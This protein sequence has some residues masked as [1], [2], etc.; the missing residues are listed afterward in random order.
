MKRLF[1]VILLIAASFQ[2]KAACDY[3]TSDDVVITPNG[4]H[5][6][7][8]GYTQIYVL[9][10]SNGEIV[11]TSTN[12]SFGPQNFGS[13]QAYGINY[14]DANAPTTLPIVGSNINDI[15]D[16][17]VSLSNSLDITVCETSSLST[18]E[19]SGD[20]II[21]ALNPDY[22]SDPSYNQII[23][24][25]DDAT[26]NIV[27][28]SNFD[29]NN[30]TI[31][32]TTDA[33]IGDLTNGNYTAYSIN[34]ENSETLAGLGIVIGNSWTGS[35]G[36][37]CA[38]ASPGVAILVDLCT[39]VCG[40]CSTPDCLIAGPYSDYSTAANG[41]NHCSQIN[42]ISTTPVNG[43]TFTSY[44]QLTS[45]AT[46]TVGVV[47]SVGV[48]AVVGGTPCPVTRTATLY[49][50][51]GMCN[52]STAIS[53]STTTANGSPFYNPEFTG[54]TPNTDY[55]LEVI[56][57]VPAGC[58]MVDH[59][60][61]YYT[62][63][64]C[65]ASTGT[66]TVTGGT[67]IATNDYELENCETITFTATNED[68]NGGVLTYGWAIFNCEP[69]LPLSAADI[70]D[71][72]NNPCYVGS[73]YGLT[74]ND[75]D[76]AG[77]SA[78]MNTLLGSDET[79]LWFLPY[80]SDVD[81]AVDNDGD[82][83]YAIG[84]L[85]HITYIPPTCGDCNSPTCAADG[86][87]T[88]DDRTYNLCNDPCADLNNTTIT[89]FHTVTTDSF[90]NVGVVQS[91][92]ATC[93]VSRTAVLRDNSNS[94]GNP[95]IMPT[96]SNANGVGSGFNPEW[97]G[98]TPN[99]DYTLIITTVIGAGCNYDYACVDFYGVPGCQ[100]DAGNT[101][102]TTSNTT[103]NDYILCWNESITFTNST[104]VLSGFNVNEGF[105]YAVY[106]NPMPGLVPN[107]SDPSFIEILVGSG[108]NATLTLANDG[109][110]TPPF[111]NN[112]DHTIYL[113]PV[114]LDD[115]TIPAIDQDNDNCFDVGN[116]IQVTFLNDI[117]ITS[118]EDCLN[119][120][121]V[122]EID[123]GY[124]EYFNG[125]YSITCLGDGVL[126]NSTVLT[127]GGLTSIASLLPGDEHNIS[128]VDD[129]GC[130]QSTLPQ[131]YPVDL[132]FDSIVF[133]DPTCDYLCNGDVTIYSANASQFAFDNSAYQ[134]SNA[135]VDICA[136]T[137]TVTIEDNN[138]YVDSLITLVN[139]AT[140][141]LAISDDTTI[142][143]NGT[144]SLLAMASGGTGTLDYY[145]DQILSNS[146]N[147][148]AP[149]SNT[150]YSAYA[151]DDNSCSTDT[152]SVNVTILDALT[153]TTSPSSSICDGDSFTLTASAAGG[154]GNYN[155]IWTDDQGLG[156]TENGSPVTVIPSQNT[157]Y[158]VQVNDGCTTP[159]STLT[160]DITVNSIPTVT[161]LGDQ[162]SGCYP[163]TVNFTNTTTSSSECSWTIGGNTY[164][165][166]D[167]S[168]TFDEVGCF[169]IDLTVTSADGCLGTITI[170]E[171]ICTYDYPE[172]YFEA[173]D[174]AIS[175]FNPTVSFQNLSIDNFANYWDFGDQTSEVSLDATH[176]YPEVDSIYTVCLLVE[177]Q[178][179][180][181]DEFCRDIT[182]Q[183]EMTLYVPN[184]FTPNDDGDNDFFFPVFNEDLLDSFEMY[185]YN[186]WGELIFVSTSAFTKWDGTFQGA[187]CQQ[188]TYVWVINYQHL[189]SYQKFVY[190][191]HVNLFR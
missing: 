185:I 134:A 10:N 97:I 128:V 112:P 3:T 107:S 76:A 177:N 160:L 170:P 183:D 65:S 62:P 75:T 54:L 79:E 16:G 117:I 137:F 57:S 176:L 191:G 86:V 1:L 149:L 184:T 127:A 70:A 33:S 120:S 50:L 154:D 29:T 130:Q 179:G 59:C 187:E 37:A 163:L 125:S 58:D 123:G 186:R 94:C 21:I 146:S 161:F 115:I 178:Y 6:S 167:F 84:D 109:S 175:I 44:H 2:L 180:C 17:C 96:T 169:D 155:F 49:P 101:I 140:L 64:S 56:F 99:T 80:T 7:D 26:G 118:T 121:A 104:F 22:N 119:E 9:T 110:Y 52:A 143:I 113:Y 28:V 18:C 24:V 11:A 129:N 181:A 136:G 8:P 81:D 100:N 77:I 27:Q 95:D 48:N 47:I 165:D 88:F 93:T 145:W 90:G 67:Q 68:L 171:Y 133:N 148:V 31:N 126:T 53:L 102:A 174:T 116:V 14:E 72:N 98:L 35:F 51:G 173:S 189:N 156:W 103:N 19:D 105:G 158:T 144:A 38:E 166:C 45:S 34:Y 60:E 66:V 63:A 139:P 159:S 89:T 147:V 152:L 182:I 71:L 138:C 78:S 131:L 162:T 83:C 111:I 153:L 13:Y 61:S 172:A 40:T 46:G 132:Q 41:A 39:L 23:V 43:T 164:L 82:G 4:N 108:S 157:Q 150:N 92:S 15:N 74:T 188:D 42:D 151:L 73:D 20:D 55:V 190:K 135:F 122:Y 85:I 12:G 124:V 168:Y 141:D 142:C 69:T 5:N 87:A 114:T 91:V 32:Y 25:V 30:G 106:S 36:G